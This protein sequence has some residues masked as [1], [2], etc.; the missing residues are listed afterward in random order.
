MPYVKVQMGISVGKLRPKIHFD[1][2]NFCTGRV[3]SK[4]LINSDKTGLDPILLPVLIW[5]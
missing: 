4:D 1:V 3:H 2:R 5:E